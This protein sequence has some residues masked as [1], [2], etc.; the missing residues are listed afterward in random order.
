MS[1]GYNTPASGFI[2]QTMYDNCAYSTWEHDSTTPLDYRLYLGKFENCKNECAM[3]DNPTAQLVDL[4]S[5]LRNQ[6]RKFSRC[7]QFQYSP[8]CKKSASCVSTNDKS[9]PIVLPPDLCPIVTSGL[10]VITNPGYKMPSMSV[11]K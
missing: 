1:K 3:K 5:E 7:P 6:T 10:P 8:T 4:E 9:V 2:N 11:C